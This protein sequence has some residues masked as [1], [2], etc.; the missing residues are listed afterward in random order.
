[1]GLAVAVGMRMKAVLLAL[2]MATV[3]LSGCLSEDVTVSDPPVV[4][5]EDVRIF[6]TDKTGNSLNIPPIDMML[7]LIHI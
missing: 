3:S 2:L 4:E 7:S 6:V 1:M 5:E